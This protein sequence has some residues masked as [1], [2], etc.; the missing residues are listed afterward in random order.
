MNKE[1]IQNKAVGEYYS[2]IKDEVATLDQ[3]I[4]NVTLTINQNEEIK[5][6]YVEQREALLAEIQVVETE[7]PEV[8]PVE[9]VIETVELQVK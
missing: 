4:A 5:A 3:N 6:K 2:K 7:I 8:K 9:E 1:T